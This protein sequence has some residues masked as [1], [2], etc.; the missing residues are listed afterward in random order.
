MELLGA[1]EILKSK[2]NLCFGQTQTRIKIIS[3]HSFKFTPILFLTFEAV[4]IVLLTFPRGII[5]TRKCVSFLR[6]WILRQ[7]KQGLKINLCSGLETNSRL[8]SDNSLAKALFKLGCAKF[9]HDGIRITCEHTS[10]WHSENPVEN[11]KL[12]EKYFD[13]SIYHPKLRSN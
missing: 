1:F 10:R 2:K 5:N 7:Q 12:S 9:S 11:A 4:S 6:N 8:R 13:I 3:D